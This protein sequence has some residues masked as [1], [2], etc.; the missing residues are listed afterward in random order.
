MN[1][2]RSLPSVHALLESET[3][4][5]LLAEHGR[6]AVVNALREALAS[7]RA[8]LAAEDVP[9]DKHDL[10]EVAGERLRQDQAGR[11]RRVINATGVLLHTGLGRAPLA[12]EA[13]EAVAQAAAGYC[14]LEVDLGTGERSMRSRAVE[15]LL[16]RLTG[17][18]AAHV[19]NNNAGATGLSVAALAEGREVIVSHGELIEIGGGYRLPKVV[20]AYGAT[21]R[22]VGTTNKTRVAD[23][24]EAIGE[25]TGAILV[26]HPSNYVVSGFVE[27]PRLG[28]LTELARR[29]GVPLIHDIGSGALLELS[30]FGCHGE[31]VACDS[32]AAGADLVLFSGDKLLG[33]PQCGILAGRRDLVDAAI[34]HSLNR[35]LRVGKMTLAALGATLRLYRDPELAV[36]RIPLLRCLATPEE[37][38]RRRAEAIVGRLH[39]GNP[40][41]MAEVERD[42]ATAGGGSAPDQA[43]PSWSVTLR[44]GEGHQ[45]DEA[46]RRLRTGATPVAARVQRDRL[47]LN[48]RSVL[49]EEDEALEQAIL[50]L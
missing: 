23:Y 20:E 32:I 37:D 18:E 43:L 2:Y 3:T 14:G 33:G 39:S 31:P 47:W 5:P 6:E 8:A 40:A 41:F 45:A 17:A 11:L 42:T 29:R 22:P 46:A 1:A 25:D 38:L 26:V 7:K 44:W 12:P 36:K 16:T 19:V 50:N 13:I 35:A 15:G 10:I 27:S 34:G 48:L 30:E 24:D 28:E 49:A 21:L 9:I 4:A